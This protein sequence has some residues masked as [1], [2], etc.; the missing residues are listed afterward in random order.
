MI[1]LELLRSYRFFS[2]YFSKPDS[3][4]LSSLLTF[5]TFFW[6]SISLSWIAASFKDSASSLKI[7][8]V[9]IFCRRPFLSYVN[10]SPNCSN[11]TIHKTQRYP[12]P[13]RVIL[14]KS[15]GK[16]RLPCSI[17]IPHES[18]CGWQCDRRA[19]SRIQD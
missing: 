3:W 7:S 4:L 9:L 11:N 16:V 1:Y 19:F 8:A 14:Y 6:F 12:H 15:C 10:G 2:F 18:C 5:S 13:A 17:S